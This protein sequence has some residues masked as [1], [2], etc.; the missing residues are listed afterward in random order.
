LISI[1]LVTA[2]SEEE[3][4][5]P[6]FKE[7]VR[8]QRNLFP[9]SEDELVECLLYSIKDE[10]KSFLECTCES[11]LYSTFSDFELIIIDRLAKERRRFTE[12]YKHRINLKHIRDKP[13]IWHDLKPPSELW[14]TPWPVKFTAV[15]NARNTAYIVAEGELILHVD[16]SVI[17]TPKVLERAWSWY[18]ADYGMKGYRHKYQ[19]ING[20]LII[21]R[22]FGDFWKS[23]EPV[24]P[25]D[26]RNCFGHCFSIPLKWALEVNGWDEDLDGNLGVED[27]SFGFRVHKLGY[28]KMVL[29]RY[30]RVY[31]LGAYHLQ[32]RRPHVKSNECWCESQYGF[33]FVNVPIKANLKRPSDEQIEKY[34]EYH[35][36]Q[37]KIGRIGELASGAGDLMHPYLRKMQEV[38]TFDLK[39]LRVKYKQGVFNWELSS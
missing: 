36:Q 30:A 22:E 17:F 29:D 35:K 31:E 20:N 7:I 32:F 8:K 2:R 11:L 6:R 9:E 12:K 23:R 4:Q 34:I 39:D 13:S 10:Q 21:D 5:L 26:Y 19:F 16:D 27:L 25:Y 15:N 37:F 38:P 14:D 1:A 3:S 28:T 24:K 18:K 33:D